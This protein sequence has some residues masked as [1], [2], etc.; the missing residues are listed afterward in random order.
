MKSKR[1]IEKNKDG[2]IIVATGD[3]RQLKSVQPITNTQDYEPYVDSIID[4]IFEHHILLRVCKRLHTDED[5]DTLHNI[6][7]DIFANK[8]SVRYIEKIVSYKLGDPKYIS[9]KYNKA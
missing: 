8:I 7:Q 2:K 9:L 3:C 5:K 1:F 4:N 6:K